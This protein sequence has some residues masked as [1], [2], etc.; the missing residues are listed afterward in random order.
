MRTGL[1]FFELVGGDDLTGGRKKKRLW[2]YIQ[3]GTERRVAVAYNKMKKKT[4][5]LKRS[6][7]ETKRNRF[8]IKYGHYF[9]GL[10]I[11]YYFCIK[12][13][14]VFSLGP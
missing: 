8:G 10:Y 11:I 4:K 5:Y 14:L 7:E 3:T 2:I 1:P 6:I 12:I 13:I 9:S